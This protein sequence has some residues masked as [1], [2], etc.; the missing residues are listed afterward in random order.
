MAGWLSPKSPEEFAAARAGLVKELVAKVAKLGNGEGGKTLDPKVIE[1]IGHVPREKFVPMMEQVDAYA[2]RPLPIGYRQTI[3]Q[4]LIV[5]YMTHLLRLSPELK[6]LEI[7]TGSGY[8][9]AVLASLVKRVISVENVTALA[10]EAK[11]RLVDLGYNNI[12]FV[13]GDGRLGWSAK[14]PFDRIIVT[15]GAETI[16]P[17]LSQQLA[18][19]GRLLLPLGQHQEQRLI[20]VTKDGAGAVHERSLFPVAFVPLTHGTE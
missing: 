14:T 6:V 16:P 9:T 13:Q 11:A 20:L 12:D 5:A 19:N 3:S 18:P 10:S 1:A 7:G 8:Q 4:P 17:A 15:A 2:D